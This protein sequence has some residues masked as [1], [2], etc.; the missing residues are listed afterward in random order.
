MA[1]KKHDIHYWEGLLIFKN[2]PLITIKSYSDTYLKSRV[3]FNCELHGDFEAEFYTL[4]SGRAKYVCPACGITKRAISNTNSIEH[5]QALL[6][7]KNLPNISFVSYK[8]TTQ[9]D[10]VTINCT[11]HG[12]SEVRF[13]TLQ[14]KKSHI[15]RKCAY[16]HSNWYKDGMAELPGILYCV[17]LPS[18]NMWK[19][20]VTTHSVKH[21]FKTE[22][23]DIVTEWIIKF[24][25]VAQAYLLEQKLLAD[26][27]QF[28]ANLIKE[29]SPLKGSGY[30]EMF[31]KFINK[32]EGF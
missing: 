9:D 1:N 8:E 2:L 26:N 6:D 28:N 17:S 14:R 32:P 11:V 5:W 10:F 19:I 21:R 13:V 25:S 30:T 18:I 22:V 24:K 20:G 12:E 23:L 27:K 16:E 31:L 29:D 7:S 4:S 15:C 3:I